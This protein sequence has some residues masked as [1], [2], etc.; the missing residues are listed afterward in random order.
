MNSTVGVWEIVT[1]SS[2]KFIMRESADREVMERGARGIKKYG[3][4]HVKGLW[5]AEA[6][7]TEDTEG[8][9]ARQNFKGIREQY[10]SIV[11]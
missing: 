8:M 3:S 11:E 5:K 4:T 1:R 9:T 2:V 6:C 10:M 7:Y